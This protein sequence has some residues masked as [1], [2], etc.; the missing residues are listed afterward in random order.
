[1]LIKR[2]PLIKKS[3]GLGTAKTEY[4]LLYSNRSFIISSKNK[5]VNQQKIYSIRLFIEDLST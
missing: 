5:I 1:M 4:D 3:V 2:K